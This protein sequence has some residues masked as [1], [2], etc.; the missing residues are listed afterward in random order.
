MNSASSNMNELLGDIDGTRQSMDILL[1]NIDNVIGDINYMIE[2]NDGKMDA[3]LTDL[4]KTLSVIS[5]HIDTIT[6][7]LEGSSRN[8]HEFTRQIKENPGLL[9]RGSAQTEKVE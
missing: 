8:I 9:I 5:T 3:S 1:S 7:H 6:H 4:Q 2:N